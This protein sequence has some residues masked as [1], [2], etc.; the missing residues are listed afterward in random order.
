M[1][2]IYH[3]MIASL[4]LKNYHYWRGS[5]RG[6]LRETYSCIFNDWKLSNLIYFR[7]F[8]ISQ[9]NFVQPAA[10]VVFRWKYKMT[11]RDLNSGFLNILHC[12]DYYLN[13][14][15][16]LL[17]TTFEVQ[18]A[19]SWLK[20][21]WVCSRWKKCWISNRWMWLSHRNDWDQV[22]SDAHSPIGWIRGEVETI[23]EMN[24]KE[25]IDLAEAQ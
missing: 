23:F 19:K 4:L 2:F 24:K 9:K 18:L 1:L 17:I 10:H 12:L 13:I 16:A 7:S 3:R 8:D 11:I 20:N 15:T 22:K 6:A 5:G 25:I 21:I 14:C